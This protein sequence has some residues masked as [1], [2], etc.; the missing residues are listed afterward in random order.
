[1]PSFGGV[2][3]APPCT[4]DE[5]VA[6]IKNKV[7]HALDENRMLVPAESSVTPDLLKEAGYTQTLDWPMDDQPLWVRARSGPILSVPSPME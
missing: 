6:D 5:R 3:L 1:M 7:K 4:G 2:G